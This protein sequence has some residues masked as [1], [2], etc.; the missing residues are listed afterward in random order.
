VHADLA[1]TLASEH[2]D[3]AATHARV[4]RDLAERIGSARTEARLD[5]LRDFTHPGPASHKAG[6]V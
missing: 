1:L 6:L 4:A 2:P 3:D 5:T